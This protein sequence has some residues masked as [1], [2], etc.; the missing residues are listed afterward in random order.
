MLHRIKGKLKCEVRFELRFRPTSANDTNEAAV[1]DLSTESD[2]CDGARHAV[3]WVQVSI[4]WWETHGIP[5]MCIIHCRNVKCTHFTLH[6]TQFC[7]RR[8]LWW[9][10]KCTAS[11]FWSSLLLQ[12]KKMHWSFPPPHHAPELIIRQGYNRKHIQ[13]VWKSYSWIGSRYLAANYI[14]DVSPALKSY[15]KV[16]YLL[17]SLK[18]TANHIMA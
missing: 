10:R 14:K 11:L 3:A 18:F 13:A 17:R 5:I 1:W 8:N 15:L 6:F 12:K 9:F 16:L 2:F 4:N 7:P